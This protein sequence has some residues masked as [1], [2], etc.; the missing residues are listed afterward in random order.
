[1]ICG[2]G[3]DSV[4]VER[5]ENII[6]R[7][8]DRFIKRIYEEDEQRYCEGKTYPY[9]HYAARFAVK[10]AFLKCLGCGIGDGV[11]FNQIEVTLDSRGKPSLRLHGAAEKA[12]TRI[13]A[14]A[15]HVSLTHTMHYA[16][17]V[18]ILER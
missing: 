7:W 4:E 2:L 18:V 1:M 16:S 3:I 5:I 13:D 9:Q 10:E 15:A 12:L 6:T 11:A 8:G 17:A 14:A